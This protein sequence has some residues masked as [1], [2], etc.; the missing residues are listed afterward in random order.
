MADSLWEEAVDQGRHENIADLFREMARLPI[1][2]DVIDAVD[3]V[4]AV[5][6]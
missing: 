2:A 4:D 6:T 1:V 5:G 3:A